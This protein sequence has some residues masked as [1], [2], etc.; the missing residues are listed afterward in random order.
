MK[1]FG[2]ITELVSAIFRKDSQQITLRPNSTTT[3]TNNRIVDLP[4]EDASG[5]LMSA[6]SPATMTNKTFDANGT[7]NSLSNVEPADFKA[8]SAQQNQ[9]LVRAATTGAVTSAFIANA[10]ISELAAIADSKLAT[11]FTAGKVSNSATTAT[12]SN[13]ASAIVSRDASGNFS[14]GT[15]TASLSGNVTGNVTGN[16]SGTALN[17]TGIV[18]TANGGTGQ[19]STATFP[20]SGTVAVLTDI[21][22]SNLS[23][24][25]ATSKGG[26]G[27]N[28]TAVFPT[29][30]TVAVIT[31]ISASQLSG[32]VPGS[33]GGT[34]VNNAGTLT[35][36]TNN[37]TFTTSGTTSLTLPASGTVARLADITTSQITGTL[38]ASKG[39]TGI[40][41]N[42]AATLTR[43]GNFDLNITTTAASAVTMPTSGTL[44]TRAGT[45]QLT[46]KDIDGLTASNT[47]RITL[48]KA[49]KSTLDGLTRKQATLVYG[50]DTNKVYA[51]DGSTLKEIGSGSS[52]INY[53]SAQ[54]TADALGTVQVSV[55]DV[56]AS[57]TRSNPTQWGNSAASALISQ[58]TDSTLRG[59]TNYLV[60]YTANGQF[61]ESPLFSIDGTDLAEPLLVQFD[62]SGVGT[63][64]DVQ[65]Y[66]A[67][68]NSSNVLQERIPIAGIAS[69]TTPN[70]AQVPTGVT[71]FKGFFIPSSTAGDKYAIRWLRNANN[72][73]MRLDTFFVGPQSIAQGA[74]VTGWQNYTPTIS[75]ITIGN[76]TVTAKYRRIGNNLQAW[77]DFQS[78]TTTT[79]SNTDWTFTLPS[80]L[81]IDSS[82][83]NGN[84]GYFSFGVASGKFNDGTDGEWRSGLVGR[85]NATSVKVFTA[86]NASNYT[87]NAWKSTTTGV[88][89]NL[90]STSFSLYFDVPIAEW[91]S[92]T[93]TLADRA[94]EEYAWNSDTGVSANTLYS[95]SSFYGNG[96]NGTP[97]LSVASTSTGYSTTRY[98]VRFQ[99]PILSTDNIT[100]EASSD[101][102]IWQKLENH[103]DVI[104]ID[105]SGN[106]VYGM[107][108]RV[109]SGST[110]DIDVMF[111]NGGRSRSETS[112]VFSAA[113]S[114]WSD[115]NQTRYWRVRKVSGGAAVGFPVSARNIV[116]DTSG[117]AVPAGYVG[118]VLVSTGTGTSSPAASG[119]WSSIESLTLTK[120]TWMVSGVG[121]CFIPTGST[122]TS[123]TAFSV[124][125][126]TGPTT[127]VPDGYFAQASNP[128]GTSSGPGLTVPTRVITV[129][130]DTQIV[131]LV[132]RLDYSTIGSIVLN[133]IQSQITAV[134]IA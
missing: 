58:S 56:L 112:T 90:A 37:I 110:T 5:V 121:F 109:V 39:G 117:T 108:F 76:G 3:Y 69:A 16:V 67:R 81:N 48:P 119:T 97:F 72:T 120:G 113:G 85:N 65:V 45:E 31:D 123:F 99:T 107:G 7:G 19:N 125:I 25:L 102:I 44:A 106:Y 83:D 74:V 96:P 1:L 9:V 103:P 59:T 94:L 115:V 68:Y 20:G 64:D 12:S 71:T 41:N 101:R 75:N 8:E 22:A 27:Q 87:T 23:G 11:I 17:V 61:V 133:A 70:S 33:K 84:I 93:T 134:R 21:S 40:S 34:G 2:S 50:S 91:S 53:L 98:R 38:A 105:A 51:D 73:S 104:P 80:G 46:N 32:I 63:A 18:A 92:G 95:T 42:D 36:G 78:G 132:A 30:G 131:Y 14:A 26:T 52:G 126:S 77:I 124:G 129:S 55:G 111:G 49:S 89:N 86:P 116:G 60:A 128:V 100:I 82:I 4:P 114:P 130:S 62:V 29:S 28:S 79:Y 10:N 66:I 54:Y 47:S 57:S 88:S 43:T 122:H 6:T 13:A 127:A 118:E 15:I 24:I 35:Y